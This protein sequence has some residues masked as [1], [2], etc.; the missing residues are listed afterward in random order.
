MTFSSSVWLC[1]S[2]RRQYYPER[3]NPLC[4][5]MISE[6]KTLKAPKALIKGTLTALRRS[7]MRELSSSFAKPRRFFNNSAIWSH[8]FFTLASLET[9]HLPNKRLYQHLKV[10]LAMQVVGAL[11]ARCLAMLAL[12]KTSCAFDLVRA[13]GCASTGN[14]S[15]VSR[16]FGLA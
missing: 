14:S 15:S 8:R 11:A 5:R 9:G 3:M 4:C 2:A 16:E 7:S 10:V 1:V 12:R 6:T 13:A